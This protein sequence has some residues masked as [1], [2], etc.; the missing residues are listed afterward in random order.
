MIQSRSEN[1]KPVPEWFKKLVELPGVGKG[2]IHCYGHTI[3][4]DYQDLTKVFHSIFSEKNIRP[5]PLVE[6]KK[7][8]PLMVKLESLIIE[9]QKNMKKQECAHEFHELSKIYGTAHNKL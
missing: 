7:R 2:W 1:G 5:C 4:L 6:D 8:F 9:M 3:R